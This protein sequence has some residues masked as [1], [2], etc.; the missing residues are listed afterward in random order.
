MICRLLG[1]FTCLTAMIALCGAVLLLGGVELLNALHSAG[2]GH[3]AGP[4]WSGLLVVCVFG[5]VFI[6]VALAPGS[7]VPRFLLALAMYS[8]LAIA[9]STLLFCWLEY[10]VTGY[11]VTGDALQILVGSPVQ[12]SLHLIS[13]DPVMMLLVLGLF[14]LLLAVAYFSVRLAL[15]AAPVASI[16]ARALACIVLAALGWFAATRIASASVSGATFGT[17]IGNRPGYFD[18]DIKH[19]ACTLAPEVAQGA[20]AAG[21]NQGVPVI[22]IVM[23]SLRSDVLA[24]YRDAMP[25]LAALADESVVFDRAWSTSTHT[26][27]ATL[28]LWYSRYPLRHTYYTGYPAKAA[29]RGLSSFEYFKRQGY[30]TGYFSSQNEKW[31]EMI[32]WM[33]VPGVDTFFDS[34]RFDGSTWENPDAQNGLYDMIRRGLA[35]S[36]K[37]ADG[38]TLDVAAQWIEAHSSAPIFVG[39]NLQNTH[40]NYYIPADEAR[41]YLP[42]QLGFR[43][44]YGGWPRDQASIVHN[45]YLN[46]AHGMDDALGG[47]IRRL[48]NSGVWDRAV[49]LVVGDHGEAFYEH[50]EGNHSGPAYDEVTRAVALMKLPKGDA[51]NGTHFGRPVSHIDFIPTVIEAA[52]L[53]RWSGFQGEPVWWRGATTPIYISVNGLVKE[54]SVVR[55][56]YKLMAR[57]YPSPGIE[58]YDLV[59]D[60]AEQQNLVASRQDVALPLL[61]NLRAWEHCQL[62]YYADRNAYTTLQPPSYRGD[63]LLKAPARSPVAAV[64]P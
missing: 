22:V 18:M 17:L 41:P 11:P 19:F 12:A 7:R 32:N 64:L 43:A 6:L 14:I 48:R 28:A 54:N 36:G 45:R 20:P 42:D 26:N 31:A 49:V 4:L 10:W 34:E 1:R 63:L 60:P 58:L 23:E 21:P 30:D 53:P 46:A 56:P 57:N 38:T 8:V 39:I 5:T 50:G 13:S 3:A 27:Y 24:R 15:R 2:W 52:G 25:N 59:T 9:G 29:W 37:V 33:N 16:A 35:R 44:V 40:Y 55:W 51:R 47:F 62:S 61:R